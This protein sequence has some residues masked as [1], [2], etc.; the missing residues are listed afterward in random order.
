MGDTTD[1]TQPTDRGYS[2]DYA[3]GGS[4][5]ED[6]ECTQGTD[7]LMDYTNPDLYPQCDDDLTDADAYCT[8]EC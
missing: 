4:E 2:C 5:L 3:S 6:P 1:C 7:C 8:R